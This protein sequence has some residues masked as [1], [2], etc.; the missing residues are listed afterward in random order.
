MP[1]QSNVCSQLAPFHWRPCPPLLTHLLGSNFLLAGSACPLMPLGFFKSPVL[2]EAEPR[3]QSMLTKC[4]TTELHILPQVPEGLPL[5][6]WDV[7][8]HSQAF[9]GETEVFVPQGAS[10]TQ[11]TRGVCTAPL[12]CEWK[13]HLL[14][15]AFLLSSSQPAS[16]SWTL[17]LLP[18]LSMC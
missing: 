15:E 17:V 1:S 11:P 4:S 18:P 8:K 5:W 6:S 12:Q 9:L 7:A 2:L 13:L 16:P 3:D 10:D 14:Q